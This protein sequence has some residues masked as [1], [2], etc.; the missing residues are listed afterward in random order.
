MALLVPK[1]KELN[2][3]AANPFSFCHI[4]VMLW[5]REV[6]FPGPGK[7]LLCNI[8]KWVVQGDTGTDK[9]NDVIEKGQLS[10]EQ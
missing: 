2:T 8:Q 9:V 6:P 4:V 7:E 10:G 5:H 1:C 3:Y